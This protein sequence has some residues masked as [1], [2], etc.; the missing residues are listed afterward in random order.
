MKLVLCI[1]E[2]LSGLKINFHKSEIYC[3]GKAKELR[4]IINNCLVVNRELSHETSSGIFSVKS[5]H[6]DLLDD[7]TKYLKKYI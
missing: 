2:Q 4:M 6:L 3:F 5:M 7:D 1:F